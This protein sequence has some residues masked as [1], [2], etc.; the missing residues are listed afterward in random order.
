MPH[1]AGRP[2]HS[3]VANNLDADTGRAMRGGAVMQPRACRFRRR[4]STS[5]RVLSSDKYRPVGLDLPATAMT[6]FNLDAAFATAGTT[7]TA[8]FRVWR[9]VPRIIYGTGSI[10]RRFDAIQCI[11]NCNN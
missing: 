2:V 10:A 5:S 8:L 11:E 3:C 7:R 6:V 4:G 9:R 1:A